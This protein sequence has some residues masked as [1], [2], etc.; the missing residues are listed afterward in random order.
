MSRVINAT[1]LLSIHFQCKESDMANF[2]LSAIVAMAQNRVIGINNSLPWHLPNDLKYFKAVTM[3][4]PVIMGRKTFESI[5]RP[6]PGRPNI[7]I[8]T[9]PSYSADGITVVDSVEKAAQ[10]AE[11]LTLI[12]GGNEAM[13][14]GGEQ[15]YRLFLPALNK[16]YITEV[17]A[18]VNGDA[19]FPE[20]VENE[21]QEVFCQR[22]NAE[23]P[24][25]YDYQIRVLEKQ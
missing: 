21:W 15:I 10:L 3:G 9:N 25:P 5:G 8:S 11:Q 17:M 18:N 2:T 4:K 1:T 22:H 24:N 7:V 16:L 12:N 14:I 19:W 13:V 6:L 23:G 20:F